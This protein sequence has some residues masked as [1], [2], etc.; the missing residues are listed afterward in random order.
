VLISAFF[1]SEA[2]RRA[3]DRWRMRIP[4]FGKAARM[5]SITRFCR[6]LGTML[7]N[8]VPILQALAI[9]KDSA[10][11]D[12]LARGIERASEAVRAGELLA[13]PLRTSGMFPPEILEM[14]AVAEESNQLEKVLIQIAD[15]VDKRTSRQVDEAVRFIEPMILVLIAAA[16]GFVAVGLLY[17]IFNLARTLR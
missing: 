14:V 10:G 15:K 4:V 6:I 16:I 12:A 7:A 1:R 8:G 11:S 17:P 5:V 13:E 9:S 2:G 3:W